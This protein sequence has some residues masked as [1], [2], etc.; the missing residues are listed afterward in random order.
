[1]DDPLHPQLCCCESES[2][3]TEKRH[4]LNINRPRVYWKT[5]CKGLENKFYVFLL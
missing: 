4:K 5:H 1:M 3:K 2:Y